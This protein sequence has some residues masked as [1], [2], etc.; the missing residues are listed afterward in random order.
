MRDLTGIKH[1]SAWDKEPR[2]YAASLAPELKRGDP[3]SQIALC[4]SN[5]S[6]LPLLSDLRDFILS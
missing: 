5:F 4:P 1:V 2:R 6:Y 3:L